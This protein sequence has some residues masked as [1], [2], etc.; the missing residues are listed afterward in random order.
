MAGRAALRWRAG[1]RQPPD[2]TARQTRHS[3]ALLY[4][5]AHTGRLPKRGTGDW[6]S[7]HSVRT[8]CHMNR[9]GSDDEIGH[10]LQHVAPSSPPAVSRLPL[11]LIGFGL[12]LL[13]CLP[14]LAVGSG[15]LAV[16]GG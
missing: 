6:A 3:L 15:A 10:D 9:D 13:L 11:Y 5:P 16:L 7:G 8:W 12:L 4:Q 14:V 1:G 2:G